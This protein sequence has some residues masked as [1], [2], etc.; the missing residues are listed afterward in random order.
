MIYVMLRFMYARDYSDGSEI[1]EPRKAC[2]NPALAFNATMYGLADKYDVKILKVLAQ[3][4]FAAALLKFNANHF[5]D[6]VKAIEI[7]YTTTL[8]SD[9]GLRD[10]LKPILQEWR[11][12][13]YH[14]SPPFLDLFK[15]GIADGDFT[16]DTVNAWIDFS[17]GVKAY[18][19][20]R[21]CTEPSENNDYIACMKCGIMTSVKDTQ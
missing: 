19:C 9:R 5:Q 1:I 17:H 6:L 3:N 11:Y 4:K 15:S 12:D 8:S 16:M 13:L 2:E 10:C 14:H 7:I 18:Y 20:T 21:C